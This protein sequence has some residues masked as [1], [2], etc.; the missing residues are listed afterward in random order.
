MTAYKTSRVD[1]WPARKACKQASM[2]VAFMCGSVC[3]MCLCDHAFA[4]HACLCVMWKK[5]P[6][7][8]C[9]NFFHP[10]MLTSCWPEA[11]FKA[12]KS[13][14]T[15]HWSLNYH[16][17]LRPV[18]SSWNCISIRQQLKSYKIQVTN[19]STMLFIAKFKKKKKMKSH[20][21]VL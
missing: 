10:F 13:Q 18:M 15:R 5:C 16:Q 20:S 8:V 12:V 17:P 21:T 11:S 14:V 7:P 6:I 4:L 2:S 1:S 3:H 19:D 9:K